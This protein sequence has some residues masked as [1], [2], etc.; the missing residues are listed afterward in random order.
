M[1]LDLGYTPEHVLVGRISLPYPKYDASP[2]VRAFYDPLVARVRAIPGVTEVGLASR[3]PLTRGNQQNNV[4]AEGQEP[5]AGEPVRVTN[6]RIVTP[7]Y[8][9]AMGTAL[10]EGRDFLPSDDEHSMRVAVV[11]EAFAKHFWPGERAIGKRVRGPSDTSSNRW[12]TVIGVVKNVKHNRLDE[13][14]DIQLYETFTR[15]ATWSNYLVVRSAAAPNELTSRIRAEIKA[16]DPT[17]P[18]YEVRTMQEAV[19]ASLAVRRLT[20]LLLAGFAVTALV[21]AAIGIYGV[22]ALSVSARVREFGVR[23]AL[24][25]RTSDIRAMVLRYGLG[26]AAAGVVIGIG[27]ASYLTRFLEH[28]LFGVQPFDALTVVAVVGV[29]GATAL[30]A[31]YLPARRATRA[32]PLLAL[33]AD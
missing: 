5:R 1:R 30:L 12:V 23:I 16:L 7:G 15:Y 20:N 24:G 11:D 2:A 33:R 28:L 19:S 29:L 26:L 4:V 18:F 22:I 14:T 17:L 13:A 6:V 9:K 8:F 31:A 25:A 10:L 21:L 3:I 27:A 32:D